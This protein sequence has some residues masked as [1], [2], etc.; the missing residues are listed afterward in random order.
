MLEEVLKR[1][2]DLDQ[3]APMQRLYSNFVAGI[4]HMPVRFTPARA[5]A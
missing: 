2:P 4:K 1:L 3:A 5:A